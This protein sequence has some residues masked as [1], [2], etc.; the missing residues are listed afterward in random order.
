MARPRIVH[1]N[2]TIVFIIRAI[3][4]LNLVGSTFLAL[5]AVGLDSPLL[6]AGAFVAVS[7]CP[8]LLGFAAIVDGVSVLQ[9]AAER[10]LLAERT[11]GDPS[12]AEGVR[13]VHVDA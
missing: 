6:F 2:G 3:A 5:A 8:F 9:V 10:E 7:G 13:G 4:W 1:R 12:L 11:T